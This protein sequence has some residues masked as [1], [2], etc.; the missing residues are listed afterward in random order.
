MWLPVSDVMS[1]SFQEL[2]CRLFSRLQKSKYTTKLRRKCSVMRTPPMKFDSWSLT[3]QSVP[4]RCVPDSF[5][6]DFPSL[7]TPLVWY[8]P[9]TMS[10]D[11]CVPS[12]NYNN[13]WVIGIIQA[14]SHPGDG[15]YK[16]RLINI[17]TIGTH[18]S[19]IGRSWHP[20]DVANR[21]M[22]LTFLTRGCIF[23]MLLSELSNDRLVQYL[24]IYENKIWQFINILKN[25]HW[26]EDASCHSDD[27]FWRSDIYIWTV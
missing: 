6:V 9:W 27:L 20:Y 3:W 22:F 23:K 26:L 14:T 13:S 10:A 16:G 5:C 19:W 11:P 8:V 25:V 2:P 12:L 17:K 15:K 24:C 7:Y 18:C 21:S 1:L 4:D